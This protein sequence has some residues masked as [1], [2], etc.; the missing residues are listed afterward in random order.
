[1]HVSTHLHTVVM[2]CESLRSYANFHL[3]FSTASKIV[4]TVTLAILL[5]PSNR[6]YSALSSHQNRSS[7]ASSLTCASLRHHSSSVSLTSF[8][9][10][11]SSYSFISHDLSVSLCYIG[12]LLPTSSSY[13]SA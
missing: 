3:F 6:I 1:I 2:L 10:S 5:P 13:R 7:S 9:L 12:L 11:I 4:L 8:S